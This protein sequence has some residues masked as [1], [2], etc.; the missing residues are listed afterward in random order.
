MADE[1]TQTGEDTSW[2]A[3]DAFADSELP[4][5][6]FDEPL[7]WPETLD[8]GD[9][10][11]SDGELQFPDADAEDL[12][13]EPFFSEHVAHPQPDPPAPEAEWDA[14]D[15]GGDQ[16][17][18]HVT[19][20]S[21]L[22][23]GGAAPASAGERLPDS[24]WAADAGAGTNGNGHHG[25]TPVVTTTMAAP[26]FYAEPDRGA[27][28]W[29]RRFDLRHGNAAIIALISFVS[30]VLLGMFLSVR[31]RNV[32]DTSQ[33][34][35]TS[36]QIAVQGTLNTI[37]LT[38]TVTTAAPAPINIADLVPPAEDTT[39][40]TA[41]SGAG[42]GGGGG[43]TATTAAPGRSTPAGGGT[44]GTTQAPA[45][46]ATTAA[47]QST[48]PPETTSPP[49]TSPPVDQTT[50]TTPRRTTPTFPTVTTVPD[51]TSPTYTLPSIPGFPTFPAP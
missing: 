13:S 12:E 26:T 27:G 34:R 28:G 15:E 23:G 18:P 20:L 50:P 8:W 40:V 7:E 38:T 30:L 22:G 1:T 14:F 43:S 42:S 51:N 21:G 10:A 19:V 6:A 11:T 32:P 45:P 39:T 44:T 31:A 33:T 41:G 47:P 5:T 49:L 2:W 17:M 9:F 24:L 35:T 29:R 25:A 37:P 46:T 48:T 3:F 36:D 4:S 16:T